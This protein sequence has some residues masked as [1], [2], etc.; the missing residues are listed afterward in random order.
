MSKIRKDTDVHTLYKELSKD[1][2]FKVFEGFSVTPRSWYDNVFIFFR[3]DDPKVFYWLT[4]DARGPEHFKIDKVE[5]ESN[6]KLIMEHDSI[7]FMQIEENYFKK[8][9]ELISI[10]KKLQIRSAI[11]DSWHFRF[12]FNDSSNLAYFNEPKI[13]ILIF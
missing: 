5:K 11:G 12:S 9:F 6:R 8:A 3:N 10:M 1:S 4:Y 7:N 13:W 2:L